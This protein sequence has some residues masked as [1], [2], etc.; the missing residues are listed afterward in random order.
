MSSIHGWIFMGD[1]CI[2]YY[3]SAS[4]IQQCD[5]QG[6]LHSEGVNIAPQSDE[7]LYTVFASTHF[8]THSYL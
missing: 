3:K 7:G 1:I 2:Y 8:I 6:P 5:F 4:L